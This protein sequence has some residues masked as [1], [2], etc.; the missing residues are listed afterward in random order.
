ML[1]RVETLHPVQASLHRSRRRA[2]RLLHSR[3]DH[4]RREAGRRACL[5]R[6]SAT[7]AA[8]SAATS[9]A[10]PV[11]RRF[12]PRSR[13]RRSEAA[14]SASRSAREPHRQRRIRVP[15]RSG[16]VT[17][18]ANYPADLIAPGMLRLK[19]VFA[20]PRA[21]AHRS[22]STRRPRSRCPAWSR[23]SPRKTCPTTATVSSMPTSRVLCDDVVRHYGD[24]VA[25]VV[26]E[27]D[28]GRA[29]RR[30]LVRVE[31]EDLAGHRSTRGDAAGRAARARRSRQ[32]AAAPE[33]SPRRRRGRVRSAADVVVEGSFT[34]QWQEHA[35]LQPDA[36][37]ALL[38]QHGRLVIETAGQW[39]HEDRSQLAEMLSCP[40]TG[41]S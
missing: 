36:G 18:A 5:S 30:T 10:A 39:L 22:L 33:D 41:S 11:T 7:S 19:T 31:Y 29:T 1:S 15:T 2:V 9:A 34:T 32:R 35:Y 37:I 26:A 17:G 12:S 40:K 16:K 21:R 28:R 14:T 27:T 8:R 38:R 4:G 13:R 20:Q 3:H 6:R 23:C 24:R 25:L